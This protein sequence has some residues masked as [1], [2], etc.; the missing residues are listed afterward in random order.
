MTNI[1]KC[2]TV[3]V[4]VVSLAFMGT[5]FVSSAG[6]P[7]F[8][9]EVGDATLESVRWDKKYDD[10]SGKM[11]WS[12]QT[13]TKRV[14]PNNP[15]A[16]WKEREIGKDE[17]NLPQLLLKAHQFVQQDQSRRLQGLQKAID[18]RTA[19]IKAAKAA[20][21]VDV[22]ALDKRMADLKADLKKREA[23]LAARQA[24]VAKKQL[25]A[26]K[27]RERSV[28]RRDDVNRI[29]N[30]IDEISGEIYRLQKQRERLIVEI[31]SIQGTIERL[32]DRTRQR[33]QQ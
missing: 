2:L 8:E 13:R 26:I 27:D 22:A 4:A 7:N 17:K 11:L 19:Q 10:V 32:Q 5:V 1:S 16:P 3:F 15:T 23:A 20:K 6:G 21:V 12:A 25:A 28:R 30:Q 18:N 29:R 9:S 14:D 33:N 31:D 24:E